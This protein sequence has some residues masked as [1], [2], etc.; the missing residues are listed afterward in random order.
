MIWNN[1]VLNFENNDSWKMIRTSFNDERSTSISTNNYDKK[2]HK[3]KMH[4]KTK[5]EM[6]KTCVS[7]TMHTPW[8]CIKHASHISQTRLLWH[9]ARKKIVHR[10]H[11]RYIFNMALLHSFNKHLFLVFFLLY[12]I[13]FVFHLPCL[14]FM[15]KWFH[16][17]YISLFFFCFFACIH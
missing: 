16:L 9:G 6:L 5:R 12:F 15:L 4:K 14:S 8:Q 13:I 17:S 10:R 11:K 7:F 3:W 2:K 1:R